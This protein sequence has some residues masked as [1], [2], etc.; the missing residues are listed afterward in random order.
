MPSDGTVRGTDSCTPHRAPPP[1]SHPG[2]VACFAWRRRRASGGETVSDCCSSERQRAPTPLH[3]S[4][5]RGWGRGS[6][7][8]DFTF[9]ALPRVFS[10]VRLSHLVTTCSHPSRLEVIWDRRSSLNCPS[11][12]P[13]CLQAV[14]AE[15]GSRCFPQHLNASDKRMSKKYR[16]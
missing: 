16:K 12:G 1:P 11:A 4:P 13:T 2:R 7:G 10:P 14:V 3:P 15:S 6:A 9:S 8:S 5:P